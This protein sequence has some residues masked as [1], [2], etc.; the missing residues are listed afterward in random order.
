MKTTN[1]SQPPVIQLLAVPKVEMGEGIQGPELCQ[2]VVRQIPTVVEI[3]VGERRQ[4][5][6]VP[7]ARVRELFAAPQAQ[8]RQTGELLEGCQGGVLHLAV[9]QVEAAKQAKQVQ[10]ADDLPYLGADLACTSLTPENFAANSGHRGKSPLSHTLS[11]YSA[12]LQAQALHT[13]LAD[14]GRG[15]LEAASAR[16]PTSLPCTAAANMSCG[17]PRSP[18]AEVGPSNPVAPRKPLHTQE[19]S[20]VLNPDAWSSFLTPAVAAGGVTASP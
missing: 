14:N 7:Q 10:V 5:R 2:T 8:A 4:R 18:P 19:V 17:A 1:G 13:N 16:E 9:C 11:T 20:M 3:K 15:G 6:E 12:V